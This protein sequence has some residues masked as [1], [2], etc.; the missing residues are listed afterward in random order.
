VRL[1][2]PVVIADDDQTPISA[3][4]S[5]PDNV[6]QQPVFNDYEFGGY[7]IF[8]GIRVFVDGRADMYGDTFIREY[9]GLHELDNAAITATLDK[10]GIVW[11]I[12]HSD[13][14]RGRIFD[15]LPGWRLQY[16]DKFAS[17]FIRENALAASTAAKSSL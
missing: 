5:V 8:K 10:H 9:I 7:L 17:V 2:I 13:Y 4:A 16:T 1:Q 11:A 6:R 15:R 14:R 3:L 12:V